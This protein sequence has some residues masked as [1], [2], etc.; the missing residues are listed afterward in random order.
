MVAAALIWGLLT[1]VLVLIFNWPP[2][3]VW[4]L[5]GAIATFLLYWYDKRQ[6]QRGGGRVPEKVL[7]LLAL[8][9]GV[10]GA[11]AG[12]FLLR[13]KTQHPTFYIVNGIASVLYLALAWW[14]LFGRS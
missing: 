10:V 4:L 8:L 12:M 1:V 7:M 5:S 13:H 11:W 3:I 9:G 2:I 6:A 14:L